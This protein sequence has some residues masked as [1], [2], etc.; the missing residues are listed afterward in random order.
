ML[1]A[2]KKSVISDLEGPLSISAIFV[3]FMSI[4]TLFSCHKKIMA[5]DKMPQNRLEFGHGGGFT[6]AVTTYVLLENGRIYEDLFQYNQYKEVKRIDKSEAALFYT[7]CKKIMTLNTDAAGNMYYF[8]TMK[9]GNDST[10]KRLLFGD[11]SVATPAELESLYK[12]L[13]GLVAPK[14]Y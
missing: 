9:T 11:P 8:V 2:L 13:A 12:R 5:A 1:T 14:T 6:G 7:E 3:V 10:S 4:F